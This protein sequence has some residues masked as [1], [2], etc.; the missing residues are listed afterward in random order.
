M[1]SL[2]QQTVDHGLRR[3]ILVDR[4]GEPAFEEMLLRGGEMALDGKELPLCGGL[5]GPC[6][7]D[8]GQRRQFGLDNPGR[9]ARVQ[10]GEVV[11]RKSHCHR[12][13]PIER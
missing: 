1:E 8:V 12:R 3:L 10:R 7:D 11:L 9:R 6:A 2:V 4:G 13:A 5:G